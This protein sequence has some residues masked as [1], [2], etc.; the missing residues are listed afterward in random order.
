MRNKTFYNVL[1]IIIGC[2]AYCSVR[3]GSLYLV[4]EVI[5]EDSRT[6]IASKPKIMLLHPLT[7]SFNCTFFIA[8]L[9]TIDG[10]LALTF[11][12]GSQS[13]VAACFTNQLL[14]FLD[15]NYFIVLWSCCHYFAIAN[16]CMLGWQ[17][18][19][20][21]CLTTFVLQ[22]PSGLNILLPYL[23]TLK[24]L[25]LPNRDL[26]FELIYQPGNSLHADM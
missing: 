25:L 2:P 7:C 14:P 22:K 15:I 10:W 20:C 6:E 24:L 21:C 1:C 26:C 17:R 3:L 5:L 19:L 12:G 18:L 13:H 11:M 8:C 16:T 9:V 4:S 23:T